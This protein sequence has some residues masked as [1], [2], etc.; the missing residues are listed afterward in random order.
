MRYF[1]AVAEHQSFHRAAERLHIAQPA[2]SRQIRALED[3]L[4]VELFI[5]HS[6]GVTLTPAGEILLEDV[7][8]LLP[9]IEYAKD[10][11]KRAAMGKVGTL[12]I[13]FTTAVTELKPALAAFAAA[14]RSMP[15]INFKLTVAM[16]D[17]QQDAILKNEIDVGVLYRRPPHPPEIEYRDLRVDNYKLLVPE[18]HHLTKKNRV[19]LI[20]LQ[21]ED[22]IFGPTANRPATYREMMD[23]CT[24]AGLIPKVALV[25]DNEASL[26]IMV[27]E[28][29]GIAFCNSSLADRRPMA[30][31]S[32][33]AIEDLDTPLR[34]AAMWKKTA[35]NAAIEKFVDYLVDYMA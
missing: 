19:K 23:A 4:E 9:Q 16:S 27:A 32:Y 29:I 5:R 6:Q 34:L 15:D 33:L 7:R 20:D 25:S 35:N 17:F 30:G 11:A 1:S 13:A 2:L 31:V 28:G 18:D 22:M 10:R 12:N 21:G 8:R 24:R 3:N 26:P 14:K